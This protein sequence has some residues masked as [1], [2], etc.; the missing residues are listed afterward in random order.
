ML[1]FGAF[2]EGKSITKQNKNENAL[3]S[4]DHMVG[5]NP[6]CPQTGLNREAVM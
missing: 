1:K 5:E 2:S 3:A 4:K 6:V